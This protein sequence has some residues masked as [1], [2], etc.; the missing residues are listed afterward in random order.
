[1]VKVK[2]TLRM[3][4]YDSCQGKKKRGEKGKNGDKYIHT[5]IVC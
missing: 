2:K 5:T 3:H 1:M 4:A